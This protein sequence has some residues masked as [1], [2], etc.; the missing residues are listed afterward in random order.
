MCVVKQMDNAIKMIAL[1]H[2]I[3]VKIG[4]FLAIFVWFLSPCVEGKSWNV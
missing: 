1:N 4:I 3:L 2:F